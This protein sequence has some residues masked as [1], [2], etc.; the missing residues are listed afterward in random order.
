MLIISVGTSFG[1]TAINIAALA[2]IKRGGEEGL[3]SGLINTSRQTGG[4][5]GLAI[6]LKV[7]NV[8][9][10][11]DSSS[12]SFVLSRDVGM[13]FGYASWLRHFSRE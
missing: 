2:G 13:A 4:P 3:P 12:S 6:L 11:Q 7:S 1:I 10:L 8:G 9:V 5:I